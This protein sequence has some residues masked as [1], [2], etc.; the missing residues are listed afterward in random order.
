MK[1]HK[2]GEKKKRSVS[3]TLI[4]R[5]TGW[6]EGRGGEHFYKELFQIS[7]TIAVVRKKR[8]LGH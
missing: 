2:D 6:E 3:Q 4:R 8:H 1:E 5:K 7:C